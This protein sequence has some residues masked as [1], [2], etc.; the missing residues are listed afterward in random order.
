MECQITFSFFGGQIWNAI[1][2]GK[3]QVTG[4]HSELL[5]VAIGDRCTEPLQ[6]T[7]TLQWELLTHTTVSY[8][9][10]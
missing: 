8:P 9:S 10:P 3:A 6:D 2:Q 5:P 7:P 4:D 1:L